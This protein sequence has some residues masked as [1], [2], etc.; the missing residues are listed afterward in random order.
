MCAASYPG[1]SPESREKPGYE[2]V[3]GD[4]DAKISI[5]PIL[6]SLQLVSILRISIVLISVLDLNDHMAE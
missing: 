2:L 4:T 3:M 1:F 6:A 5:F